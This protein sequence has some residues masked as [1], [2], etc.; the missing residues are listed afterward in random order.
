M[1]ILRRWKRRCITAGTKNGPYDYVCPKG[2]WSLDSKLCKKNK[3]KQKCSTA[4]ECGDLIGEIAKSCAYCPTSGKI[5]P[6]EMINGKAK[7]K[8]GE[9][10]CDFN[11]GELVL[12]QNCGKFAQMHPCVTANKE[13]G[14]HNEA[15][16]RKLWK[17]SGCINEKVAGGEMSDLLKIKESTTK[18]SEMWTNVKKQ[19]DY[20]N[21]NYESAV[22]YTKQCYGDE[23]KLDPCEP[24]FGVN[25][26]CRQK[27]F[28][29]EGCDE[30][31]TSYPTK[32]NLD[33]NLSNNDFRTRISQME[34]LANKRVLNKDEF[35]GV[36]NAL[37]SVT[38]EHHN[39][40]TQLK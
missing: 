40:P 18:L 6:Y 12:G 30:K 37:C 34:K 21:K 38:V 27:I 36:K 5:V 35:V 15:C 25:L 1:R 9:D 4:E 31:G 13:S 8:Y 10:S 24:R 11:D 16:L 22:D 26:D 20:L 39:R 32:S 23:K 7:A 19:G 2:K 3:D 14:P 17:N 28:K 29:D 33:K